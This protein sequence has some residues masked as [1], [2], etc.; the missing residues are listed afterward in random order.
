MFLFIFRIN[1]KRRLLLLL[2]KTLIRTQ[3]LAG[4]IKTY[5]KD[6]N[7]DLVSL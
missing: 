1:F 6:L 5:R 3:R 4:D 7:E 2:F